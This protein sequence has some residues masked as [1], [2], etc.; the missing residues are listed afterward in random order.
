MD[1]ELCPEEYGLN[2]ISALF[3]SLRTPTHWR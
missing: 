3:P 2:E 1:V